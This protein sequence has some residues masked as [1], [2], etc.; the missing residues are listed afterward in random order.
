MQQ[1][2]SAMPLRRCHCWI[3]SGAVS[4]LC[5]S[6]TWALYFEYIDFLL[7]VQRLSTEI[8]SAS[9]RCFL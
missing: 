5:T 2:K 8:V 6:N 7:A 3:S 9:C 4:Q 1:V